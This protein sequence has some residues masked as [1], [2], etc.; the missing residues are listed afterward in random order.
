MELD[1]SYRRS[2]LLCPQPPSEKS[3]KEYAVTIVMAIQRQ[4]CDRTNHSFNFCV[5]YN[6]KVHH[7]LPNIVAILIILV[8]QRS[9]LRKMLIIYGL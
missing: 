2:R 3:R 8:F 7:Y 6:D 1:I 9:I 5:V 4:P